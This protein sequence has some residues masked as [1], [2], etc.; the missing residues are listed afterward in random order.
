MFIQIRR[1]TVAEGYT[2]QV[3][4][5]FSQPG[6]IEQQEGLVDLKI[7]VKKGGEVMLVA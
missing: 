2:E 7:L 3:V 4:N 6:M 5:Q 1:I